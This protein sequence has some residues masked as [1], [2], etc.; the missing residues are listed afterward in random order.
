MKTFCLVRS[1]LCLSALIPAMVSSAGYFFWTGE[2]DNVFETL[3]NE[4]NWKYDNT[5][6]QGVN[7][8]YNFSGRALKDHAVLFKDSAVSFSERFNESGRRVEFPKK[9]TLTQNL[10]VSGGSLESPIIFASSGDSTNGIASSSAFRFA[11]G[12]C[13][14]AHSGY[15]SFNQILP[16][17]GV[18]ENAGGDFSA[19]ELLIGSRYGLSNSAVINNGNITISGDIKLDS[20]TNNSG[21]YDQVNVV[22]NLGGTVRATNLYIGR[23]DGTNLNKSYVGH[24]AVDGG[25]M[26]FSGKVYLGSKG[27][28]SCAVYLNGG[29]FETKGIRR[30]DGSDNFVLFNGGALRAAQGQTNDDPLLDLSVVYLLVGENGGT[31]DTAGQRVLL[32][33]SLES[34]LASGKD[35]G[36]TFTGGGKVRVD[37]FSDTTQVDKLKGGLMYSGPTKITPGT[38]V[39]TV[40]RRLSG[41][42]ATEGLVCKLTKETYKDGVYTL[43]E[44]DASKS[45]TFTEADLAR[46]RVEP[47]DLASSVKFKLSEDA[48]SILAEVKVKRYFKL[49]IR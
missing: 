19:T 45:E 10:E 14:R 43:F 31:I 20:S 4:G 46:C 9:Y 23:K 37:Y 2:K 13:V 7:A 11:S 16:L 40:N 3:T 49:I 38:T 24:V 44:L 36:M 42:V 21:K 48:K 41:T 15:Y 47:A 17:N 27:T 29:T 30:S 6:D 22:T 5:S 18:F 39:W 32:Q 25:L 34:A 8:S 28:K 35:G 26:S 1:A 33:Q 12:C